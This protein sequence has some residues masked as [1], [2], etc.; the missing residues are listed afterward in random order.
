MPFD[1]GSHST[2]KSVGNDFLFL[3]ADMA[4]AW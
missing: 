1:F 2:N 3:I 4:A